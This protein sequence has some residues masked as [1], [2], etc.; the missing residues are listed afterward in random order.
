MRSGLYRLR[1]IR[2][3]LCFSRFSLLR[4]ARER[5][6]DSVRREIHLDQCDAAVEHLAIVDDQTVLQPDMRDP[7]EQYRYALAACDL[8]GVGKAVARV[9]SAAV[10]QGIRQRQGKSR[11]LA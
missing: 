4:P 2:G 8:G 7:G 3:D 5:F 11:A 6:R 10:A 1:G 9:T